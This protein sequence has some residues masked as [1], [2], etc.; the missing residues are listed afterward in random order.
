MLKWWCEMGTKQ[1]TEFERFTALV[2]KVL[3]VPKTE[4]NRR[5]EEYRQES[6]RKPVR[7]GR[8]PKATPASSHS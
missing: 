1:G 5:L 6:L 4:M 2:D 3:S 7:P 8:K